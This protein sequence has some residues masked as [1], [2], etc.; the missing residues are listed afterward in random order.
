[1]REHRRRD[2]LVVDVPLGAAEQVVDQRHRLGERDRRELDAVDH[3]ADGVD[4][5]HVG[6]VVLVDQHRA[7]GVE[8][9][10]TASRP[11]PAVLGTRPVA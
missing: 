8:L 1:M 4:A 11:R 7:V 10:P 9:T 6:A 3:V 2:V 5:G